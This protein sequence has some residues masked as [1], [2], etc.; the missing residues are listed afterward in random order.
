[1]VQRLGCAQVFTAFG[2]RNTYYGS[3]EIRD[4]RWAE[5][6]GPDYWVSVE[7]VLSDGSNDSAITWDDAILLGSLALRYGGGVTVVARRYRPEP[8]A[9]E[10]LGAYREMCLRE[11]SLSS[12]ARGP[13]IGLHGHQTDGMRGVTEIAMTL[14]PPDVRVI[15]T[16]TP[17]PT[18]ARIT[19]TWRDGNIGG[20][21]F[22]P[23]ARPGPRQADADGLP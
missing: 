15:C 17:L 19:D 12:T 9:A 21:F 4:V 8:G 18:P 6:P 16:G 14:P 23:E 20:G 5:D 11:T 22:N 7:I 1:L 13:V 10:K 3:E 2:P